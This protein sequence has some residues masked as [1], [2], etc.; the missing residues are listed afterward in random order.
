MVLKFGEVG[1]GRDEDS[2]FSQ[3]NAT[4]RRSIDPEYTESFGC[5]E[6]VPKCR[7]LE[8]VVR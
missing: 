1:R 4:F 7:Q 3:D 5:T 6:E 8:L 2:Y